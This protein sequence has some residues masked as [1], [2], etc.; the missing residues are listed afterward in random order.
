MASKRFLNELKECLR[1]FFAN[2]LEKGR[3]YSEAW[4][5]Q[6]P[7]SLFSKTE[8]LYVLHVNLDATGKHKYDEMGHILENLLKILSKEQ[9]Q[10]IWR[11]SVHNHVEE[12][13]Y[14]QYDH[15]LFSNVDIEER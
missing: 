3:P 10:A 9:S 15:L 11:I 6:S 8:H 5:S 13:E 7:L 1:A 12:F 4:L 14:D 2:E